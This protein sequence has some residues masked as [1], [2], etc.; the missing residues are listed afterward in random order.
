MPTLSRVISKSAL[1]LIALV[2]LYSLAICCTFVGLFLRNPS[3]SPA[4][5][6]GEPFYDND[7]TVKKKKNNRRIFLSPY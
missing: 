3:A 5:S 1:P 7:P 6:L 4:S 2:L